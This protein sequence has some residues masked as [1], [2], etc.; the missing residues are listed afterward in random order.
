[1]KEIADLRRQI[2]TELRK[3]LAGGTAEREKVLALGRR[4]GELDGE[5]SWRCAV[6]FAA[7]NRTLTD[8]QRA[9]LMKLRNLDGYQS[10]PAYIYSRPVRELALA[11]DTAAFFEKVPAR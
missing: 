5:L 3:F 9:A 1:M 11:L 10:A 2:S 8:A 4:Y 7:A 6:A